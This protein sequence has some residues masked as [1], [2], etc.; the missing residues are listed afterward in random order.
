M[1]RTIL[2]NPV[3]G[4]QYELNP[5]NL[6]FTEELNREATARVVLSFEDIE[7]VLA[8]YNVGVLFAFTSTFREIIIEK[9]DFNGVFVRVFWGVVTNFEVYPVQNDKKHIQINAVSWFGLFGRRYTGASRVF[10]NA[11]AGAIAWALISESQASDNPYSSY[12]ITAGSITASKNRDRTYRFDNVRDAI[13][14]LSNSNLNDGFDFEIDN[15]RA[16]NVFFPFKGQNRLNV[17]FD[18]K[19]IANYRFKKPLVLSTTNRVYVLGEG[20]NDEVVHAVRN[21]ANQYK[22]D[23]WLQEL[24]L[25]ERDVREVSTLIDKGDR[26]L[27]LFQAPLVEFSVEHYDND[28]S[29]FDYSVGDFVRVNMP[30]LGLNNEIKRIMKKDFSLDEEKNLGYIRTTLFT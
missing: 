28:I 4:E 21:S 30:D 25:N 12:G 5:L 27:G 17:V 7:S 24:V 22:E 6:A 23:F 16:F 11:D 10:S 8:D 19:T 29:W 15:S 2:R 14:R 3:S 26:Y 1:Y 20:V 18:E 13:I 9:K